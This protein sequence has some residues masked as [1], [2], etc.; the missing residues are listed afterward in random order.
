M[1]SM[2]II[3]ANN[4]VYANER[5]RFPDSNRRHFI[6][7]FK[8]DSILPHGLTFWGSMFNTEE[9]LT[10]DL[11]NALDE[12]IK[13]DV[14]LEERGLFWKIDQ[15]KK[16]A[17]TDEIFNSLARRE[18]RDWIAFWIQSRVNDKGQGFMNKPRIGETR[19]RHGKKK[20]VIERLHVE[21]FAFLW[22]TRFHAILC[23]IRQLK[24]V[25]EQRG[26]IIGFLQKE[27]VQDT[28]KLGHRG[29]FMI[30]FSQRYSHTMILAWNRGDE[31]VQLDPLLVG[32]EHNLVQ[33]ILEKPEAKRLYNPYKRALKAKALVFTEEMASVRSNFTCCICTRSHGRPQY[34]LNA[35][36]YKRRKAKEQ[37]HERRHR[38]DHEHRHRR[39]PVIE[40]PTK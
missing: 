21:H 13:A 27:K 35:E 25:W 22:K 33:Q 23:T 16:S 36:L 15:E 19:D 4:P 28:L 40:Q 10:E 32:T 12:Y 37:D 5:R 20:L 6:K 31:L 3:D 7:Y 24:P 17:K 29:D 30:R 9:V 11:L 39:T 26:V 2:N 1:N 14:G 18:I 34:V 38:H 8:Y